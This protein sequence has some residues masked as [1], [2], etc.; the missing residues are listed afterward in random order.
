MRRDEPLQILT[1]PFHYRRVSLDARHQHAA[2]QRRH[3]EPRQ[4]R[5]ID[6]VLQLR[7]HFPEQRLQLPCPLVEHL[8]QPQAKPFVRIG[9]LPREVAERRAVP[10]ITFPLQRHQRVDEQHEPIVRLDHRFTQ[11]G[12][13]SLRKPRELPLEHFVTELFL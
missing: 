13:P 7:S 11:D 9:Q 4:S 8:V 5:G 6:I 2:F 12:Q 10:R 3:D 1:D